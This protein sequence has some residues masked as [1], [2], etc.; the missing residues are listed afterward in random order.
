[1]LALF[2]FLVGS[3]Q[4]RF[5]QNMRPHRILQ[6]IHGGSSRKPQWCIERIEVEEVAVG[7]R[8]RTRAAVV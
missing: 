2:E 6:L 8:R 3:P 4:H 7:S 1:M 5:A